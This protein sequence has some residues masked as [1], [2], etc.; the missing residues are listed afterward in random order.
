MLLGSTAWAEFRFDVWTAESGL[1]QNTVRAIVQTADGYLWIATLDGLARFDGISFTVFNKASG[2]S[3]NG[4]R[5]LCEDHRS[6]LWIGLDDGKM[7]RLHQGVFTSF[8]TRNGLS[9]ASIQSVVLAGEGSL[10]VV[11]D[12]IPFFGKNDHFQRDEKV[13]SVLPPRDR[14]AGHRG[15]ILW[16]TN[17][18][19]LLIFSRGT[20]TTLGLSNGLPSLRINQVDEDQHGAWW[21][22]TE[23]AGLVEFYDGKVVKHYTQADGLPNNRVRP[24][25]GPGSPAI[26]CKDRQGN[27]WVNGAGP[28]LGCLRAGVFTGYPN[29]NSPVPQTTPLAP[30]LRGGV[31]NVLFEDREGNLWIGTEG[32]GLIR[33]REQVVNVISTGQGLNAANTYPIFEDHT[34]AV[35][36]G[37]WELGL[38]RVKAGVVTNFALGFPY[39][40][41]TAFC[42]DQAGRLWIGTMG[43]VL[44]FRND[45]IQL[46][47]VPAAMTNQAVR[48]ICQ[49][50]KG[51]LWFGAEGGLVSYRKGEV[52]LFTEKDGLTPGYITSII[53]GGDGSLW[54]GSRGGLVRLANGRFKSWTERD[55]LPSNRVPALYEDGDGTLWIGSADGGLGRFRQGRFTRYTT[56]EGMFDNG[57]FRILEDSRGNLWM[58]SNRGIHRASKQELNDFADGRIRRITSVSY[59][60]RDGM[61]N[62][63][64]NG[65]C[66]PSGAKTRDGKLWFPTQDGVAVIDPEQVTTNLKPPPVVIESF[67]LDRQSLALDSVHVPPGKANIEIHYTG[68]SFVSSDRLM[69]KYRLS[70]ATEDWVEAGTRRTAYYSRLAPGDYTFTVLAA[71]RDGIWNEEGA[72]LAFIVQPAWWQTLW[73]RAAAVAAIGAAAFGFYRSRITRLQQQQALQH[74]FARGLIQ[75]QEQERKRIAAELHD[76]LGQNLLVIKNRASMG[77]NPGASTGQELD[78]IARLAAQ[79]LEEVR[80]ISHNLR[81]YQLDRLGLTRALHGLV[82]KVGASANLRCS[83]DITPLDR[84]FRPEDE[85]HFFRIVQEALNNVLKHSAATEARVLIERHETT[86][87]LQVQDNGR[88]FEW[89]PKSGE[90]HGMGLSGISERTRILRGH[91]EIKSAPGQGTRLRIEVPIPRNT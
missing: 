82:K 73:F 6:N 8:D 12:D 85:V 9:G 3:A 31:I 88:G 63:E 41:V 47:G 86:V 39:G 1:P 70:G 69:F 5:A 20:V 28:W 72:S 4:I 43:G 51:T 65:G 64:C 77:K 42:E 60:K 71:N 53:E 91:L 58:S 75:S 62:P 29:K 89:P 17:Q 49:D 57:V 55:G 52:S 32:N 24:G 66:W 23:D 13:N 35:W 56:S 36:L 15:G 83:A 14:I 16:S 76:S 78:E 37:T 27:L 2:L 61:L 10:W 67:L 19:A 30:D 79:S 11:A 59:G 34:G 81:P 22:A 48:A 45:A 90:S 21:V 33:A 84:L 87:E 25:V 68:L 46:E 44:L 80:E 40:D 38:A 26:A 7:A 74:E 54:F 18:D 50:R